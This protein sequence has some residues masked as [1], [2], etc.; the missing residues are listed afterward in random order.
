M[1]FGLLVI[2]ALLASAFA[3]HA[4][5]QDPGY[6]VI[7]FRGYLV[8]MS[9]PVLLALLISL[10]IAAWLIRRLIKA[11]RQ[12]GEA[13]ARYRSGRAGDRLTR[14]M[15][16]IA[17]GNFT[18]GERMLARTAHK[19]DAPLL[20]YL[21]A[22]RAAHLLGQDERRDNWLKQA[23]EHTPEAANAVLLTQA[24]LQLDQQQY[25]QALATL[26]KLE[27]NTPNHARAVVLLGRVYYKLGDA[28]QLASLLP[29]I[30]KH[31]QL[32]PEIL[33]EWQDWVY[34]EQL[35]QAADGD[36]VNAAWAAIPKSV[37]R[38]T[39][40]LD[41]YFAGLIRT[42][43]HQQAERDIVAELKKR[44]D[45]SL[46][47]YYGTL[48]STDPVKQLKRVEV[49]L[50]THGDDAELLMTAAKLCVRAELWG[51]ARNYLESLIAV[52]PTPEAYKDYGQLLTLLGERDAAA[53][54]YRQ[55]LGLV[56]AVEP[57]SDVPRLA[58]PPGAQ[59]EASLEEG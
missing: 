8:E 32:K 40:L 44:W 12:L 29:R 20:N 16:E 51:K 19:S 5:L 59:S 4:L 25:E 49:W 11:P 31:A 18:K 37:R 38:S 21:Q 23:Y 41:A 55:G 42:G 27:E 9:V 35:K 17:E 34:Q 54:A 56:G 28:D 3:A 30:R 50:R 1:K 13:A 14:G 10:L 53:D 39:P 57:A 58:A 52:R 48:T 6:V 45:S 15:I 2:V 33:D 26:R 22:A 43:Q 47:R 24:E 7:N 46:V 36:Q